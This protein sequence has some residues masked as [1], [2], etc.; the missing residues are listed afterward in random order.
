MNEE[1]ASLV[2]GTANEV[3]FWGAKEKWRKKI[4]L[5]SKKF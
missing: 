1:R 4:F 2:T 5:F 3:F